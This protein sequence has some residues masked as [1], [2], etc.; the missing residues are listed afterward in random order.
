[1][2]ELPCAE[3]TSWIAELEWP[4]EV[5]SLLEVGTNGKDLMDQILHA[6]NA[7]F[8]KAALDE[9]VVGKCN[10]LL[11]DLSITTLVDEL[12]DGLQ[13]GVAIGDVRVDNGEHLLGGFGQLDEDAIVDLEKS[14]ELEDLARLRGDL[15]DTEDN[16]HTNMQTVLWQVSL[17]LDSDNEDELGL[18]INVEATLLLAQASE[19]DLLALRVAVFLDISLGPLEDCRALFLVDLKETR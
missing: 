18:L 2:P 19:P 6:H 3:S 12:A 15:V 8:A 16:E 17:P 9:R 14:E 5:G 11:L 4:Q 1:M 13:V 7:I 10:A